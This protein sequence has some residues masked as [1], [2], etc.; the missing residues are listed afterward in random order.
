MHRPSH[1][2]IHVAEQLGWDADWHDLGTLGHEPTRMKTK[3]LSNQ[4]RLQL[5]SSWLRRR[6]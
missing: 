3:S 4:D 5:S 6:F 1:G 2:T